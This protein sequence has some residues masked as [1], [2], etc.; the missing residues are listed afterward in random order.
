MSKYSD[1]SASTRRRH[2]TLTDH[3]LL[4]L[5]SCPGRAPVSSTPWTKTRGLEKSPRVTVSQDQAQD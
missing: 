4:S 5:H 3:I 2:A 1:S